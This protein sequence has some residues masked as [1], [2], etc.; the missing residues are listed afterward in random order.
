MGNSRLYSCFLLIGST[1]NTLTKL[2]LRSVLDLDEKDPTFFH[3]L[4]KPKMTPP[5]DATKVRIGYGVTSY[6]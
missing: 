3:L 6:T 1:H 2:L 5:D 4:T